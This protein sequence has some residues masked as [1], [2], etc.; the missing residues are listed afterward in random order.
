MDQG[1]SFLRFIDASGLRPGTPVRI[2]RAD[3]AGDALTVRPGRKAPVTMGR[4]AARKVLVK[5]VD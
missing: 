1:P 5:T 2:E 3:S 4:A